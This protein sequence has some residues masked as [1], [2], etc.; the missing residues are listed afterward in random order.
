MDGMTTKMKLHKTKDNIWIKILWQG[1]II[2]RMLKEKL[3]SSPII[4]I[5]F[6]NLGVWKC[7]ETIM[8]LKNLKSVSF[9][10]VRHFKTAIE[11]LGC[12]KLKFYLKIISFGSVRYFKTTIKCFCF[13][14]SSLGW[15]F[16]FLDTSF[17]QVKNSSCNIT[18]KCGIVDKISSL[19]LR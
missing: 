2:T 7:S 18:G 4:E 9:G 15:I 11:C 10:S 8:C 3:K 5:I 16:I 1:L 12:L 14:I 6:R 17:Y 19:T 13:L